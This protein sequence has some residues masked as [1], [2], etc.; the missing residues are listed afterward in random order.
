[1]SSLERTSRVLVLLL[2]CRG[3]LH[4]RVQMHQVM[5]S[6]LDESWSEDDVKEFCSAA[7]SVVSVK[8]ISKKNAKR[9]KRRGRVVRLSCF[10]LFC[11]NAVCLVSV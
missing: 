5:V 2:R 11:L 10:V 4:A 9:N 6:R 1:M 3:L 8:L 7:G